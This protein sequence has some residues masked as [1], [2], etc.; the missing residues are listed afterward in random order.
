MRKKLIEF[1]TKK[2]P[3][4]DRQIYTMEL[5]DFIRDTIIQVQ[6]GVQEAI[7]ELQNGEITGAIN[8]VWGS[9]GNISK[10]EVQNLKFD[11]AVMI[12]N[13]SSGSAGGRISVVAADVNLDGKHSR[14]SRSTNSVKFSIPFIPP[15]TIVTKPAA[16]DN[17]PVEARSNGGF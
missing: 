16:D 12:E 2:P 15:V 6:T 5:K 13:T 17:P 11:I 7:T 8:P 14:E 9:V 10:S 1:F 4:S 3:Q